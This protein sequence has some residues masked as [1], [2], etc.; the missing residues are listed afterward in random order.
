MLKPQA[1]VRGRR[2]EAGQPFHR[3]PYRLLPA[4][5]SNRGNTS[6]RS[7]RWP[8]RFKTAEAFLL[9]S[10]KL[11]RE[12]ARSTDH[13]NLIPEF[14]TVATIVQDLVPDGNLGLS[15]SRSFHN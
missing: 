9:L 10:S 11:Y 15:K 7:N 8:F 13:V 1:R 5:L 3:P 12:R 14:I 4:S 6:D 2:L